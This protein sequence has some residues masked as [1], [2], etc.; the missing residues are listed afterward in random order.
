MKDKEIPFNLNVIR[1][2]ITFQIKRLLIKITYYESTNNTFYEDEGAIRLYPQFGVYGTPKI[3]K[4]IDDFD[5][6]GV[7]HEYHAKAE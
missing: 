5:I 2:H 7:F 1:Y 3:F 6:S 4:N